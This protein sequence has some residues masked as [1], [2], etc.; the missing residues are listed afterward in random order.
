MN[1]TTIQVRNYL[2]L[3]LLAA[4]PKLMAQAAPQPAAA[5]VTETAEDTITLDP[6]SVSADDEGRGYQVKDTLAGTRVRTDLRDVASALS[7]VNSQFLK[8]TGAKSNTDL[9][10]YTPN[11]EV[12]GTGGNF[13]GVGNVFIGNA[14]ENNNFARPSS[15]TRV[16][17]L[18]SAD[19][20]RDF[21]NSFIP[22]D[23]YIVDRVDLQRG[24]NSVLFGIGSAA[25]IVNT[26]IN[27]AGFKTGGK[28]ETRFG[29]F[30]SVRM[31]GDY[32]YVLKKNE[33]AF[34]VAF[35]N[36]KTQ[37]RQQPAFNHDQRFFGALKWDPKLFGAGNRTSIR[38]N[39][40]NGR[41][42]ANRPRILPPYENISTFFDPLKNN[43]R[44]YDPAQVWDRG[45]IQ[46][47]LGQSEPDNDKS[48]AMTPWLGQYMVSGAQLTANPV[49]FYD[50][51][52]ATTPTQVRVI[53]PQTNFGLK[54]DGTIDQS[55]GGF[56]FSSAIGLKG[57]GDWAR[58]NL[59]GGDVGL[60][61]DVNM[62]DASIF[63]F[64]NK[65][66][67]GP[68]KYEKN[69]WNAWNASIEQFFLNNRL[70]LQ[71]VFDKQS[72]YDEQ[73]RNLDNPTLT[74]DV[75]QYTMDY[76][77]YYTSA[78]STVSAVLNPNAGRAVTGSGTKNGGRSFRINSE[79]MR[80]TMTGELRA[81]DLFNKGLLTDLLGRHNFTALYQHDK[82]QTDN[83]SFVRYAV[84]PSFAMALGQS[85]DTSLTTGN[86]RIIDVLTYLSGD[87]RSKTSA[88]GLNLDGVTAA[89]SPAQ[90]AVRIKYFDSHWN[91]AKNVNPAAAWANV[92]SWKYFT[93]PQGD[94]AST[95]SENPANYIGWTTGSFNVLNAD[96]PADRQSLFTSINKQVVVKDSKAITYQGSLFNDILIPTIGV[97]R[98]VHTNKS[99]QADTGGLS[100]NPNL[101]GAEAS[102]I[103]KGNNTSWG[104]VLRLPKSLRNKLPFGSDISVSYNRGKNMRVENRYG[105]SGQKLPNSSGDTTDYGFVISTLDEKVQFK[106][107]W[108]KTGNKDANISS[109]PGENATLGNNSYMLTRLEGWGAATALMNK[110]GN[111][112]QFSGWEWFWNYALV[113][114]GWDS[115]YNDPTT[116]IYKTNPSTI[117][118]MAAT[119][120]WFATA[121][122]VTPQSWF[123][124]YGYK[125]DANKLAAGDLTAIQNWTPSGGVGGVQPSGAGAIGGVYPVGTLDIE[126]KGIEFELAAQPVKGLNI[127]L[128]ATKVNA[129]T[130]KL[131]QEISRFIENQWARLGGDYTRTGDKGSFTAIYNKENGTNYSGA[132]GDLRLWWGGGD[133]FRKAY[134]STIWAPYTFQLNKAGLGVGELSEWKVNGIASYS[135]DKG[136]LKGAFVGGG[137]RWQA[138]QVLGYAFRTNAAGSVIGLDPK[139]P[140]KGASEDHLDMWFGYTKKIS[141]GINWRIQ[142]NL[143][144][145]GESKHLVVFGMNPAATVDKMTPS[146]YRIAEG[147][148]WELTNAFEF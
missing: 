136:L 91:N 137:Y 64:Y 96:D 127:S 31:S 110:A 144:N 128:N 98:D 109:Q 135:F 45:T 63:D 26:S 12:S 25:C 42:N 66:I 102:S 139:K 93:N 105:F 67:D 51:S 120:D 130:V 7:V 147:M 5:P 65:L 131:G 18:D 49:F 115:K 76:P 125:I 55:I 107:N 17:G 84:D 89:Q 112:N 79:S 101:F 29:S 33:L 9:L 94:V 20:T 122:A 48:A 35:L 39:F 95:Q 60:Y 83:R 148:T 59:P 118:Q 92:G 85:Q 22:W 142:A 37:Y 16:R 133:S 80:L 123:D 138:G 145:V 113:D 54:S 143:R 70:G 99:R 134:Y 82:D 11:T 140:Y 23:S 81:T 71:L 78:N 97:R 73:A 90:S 87:L 124:A 126:S 30:G 104:T 88:S 141:K 72:Y 62:T 129:K 13:A 69:N 100:A 28:F 10:V 106:A 114:N 56:P 50:A 74:V 8:D 24:P 4:A 19:N 3:A 57:W 43:K 61:K 21:F 52:S 38:V 58:Y 14:N 6:F 46:K 40:E 108:Y 1:R 2:A 44:T 121:K 36:D 15:N 53:G 32:N 77:G 47:V 119:A 146:S 86:A 27:A 116:E 34:R 75:M 132:A 111:N 103:A 117:K 68:T 41:V